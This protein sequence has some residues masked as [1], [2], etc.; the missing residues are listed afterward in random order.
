MIR[1]KGFTLVE[2]L[3]V[4][5]IIGL[6]ISILLPTLSKAR[7]Q[8]QLVRCM[9][10]LRMIGQATINYCG[11]NKQYLPQRNGDGVMNPGGTG[12]NDPL[13][14][15]IFYWSQ[16]EFLGNPN[17]N[18]EDTTITSQPGWTDPGANIGRLI[19][20]GYMGRIDLVGG[21]NVSAGPW[22]FGA[23]RT[24]TN[25]APF[26]FCP[27]QE[28]EVDNVQ[29]RYESSYFFNPHWAY[30]SL[31]PTPGTNMVT[32][33]KKIT[34]MPHQY[35]LACDMVYNGDSACHCTTA[36]RARGICK[37]NVLFPDGH[38]DTAVDKYVLPAMLGAAAGGSGAGSPVSSTF[39]PA[40]RLDDYIDIIET[41]ADGRDPSTTT[42]NP[43]IGPES[44]SSYLVN[45]EY[46]QHN[47]PTWV[48]RPWY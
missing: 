30:S 13:Q 45:R 20:A 15:S 18:S 31:D 2:L 34:D 12:P 5:G 21:P 40:R 41:E 33:F 1:R 48:L 25:V 10:N 44:V 11:D 38:V 43:G 46:Y 19:V 23:A 6:L 24:N 42:A 9:A 4:I 47:S 16:L 27:A 37:W 3:V 36:E 17:G 39:A 32:W 29:Q 35:C 14:G 22:S 28:S 8:A 7:Q 26:R